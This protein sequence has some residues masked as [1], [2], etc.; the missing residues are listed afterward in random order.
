MN[1]RIKNISEETK[2]QSQNMMN[3]KINILV[4]SGRCLSKHLK[5]V[6]KVLELKMEITGITLKEEEDLYRMMLIS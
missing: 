4:M 3:I 2:T 6:I 5:T 1:L